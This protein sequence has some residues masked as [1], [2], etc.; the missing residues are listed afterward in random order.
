[1][2]NIILY[3]AISLDGYLAKMD[4]NLDWLNQTTGDGD[5]G[6]GQLYSRI[7]TLVMGRQTFDVINHL[8][9]PYPHADRMTY[10]FS[11]QTDLNDSETI[12][13][14]HGDVRRWYDE[15]SLHEDGDVWLVGGGKLITQF[16]EAALID[17][18]ILSIA[19]VILGEGIPL[20]HPISNDSRW[21]LLNI[22][23]FGQFVQLIYVKQHEQR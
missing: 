5:N 16:L 23:Q 4:D 20:W 7:S 3:V 18:I 1:M 15:Y 6:Y 19:P 11:H 8:I 22:K 2:P 13:V 14:V 17:E 12:R 21:H 9:E 10:I